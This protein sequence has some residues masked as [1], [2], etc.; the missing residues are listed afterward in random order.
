MI[1]ARKLGSVVA[2]VPV[3]G[4]GTWSTFDLDPADEDIAVDVVNAAF[5]AGIRLVDMSP[6]YGRAE[7]VLGRALGKHRDRA[8]VATKIWT[9]SVS[10]GRDQYQN[11]LDAFGG[12]IEL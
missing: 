5:E 3:I 1:E 9:D 10:G 6:M 11:Q 7:R 8:F 2:A 4:L 12:H